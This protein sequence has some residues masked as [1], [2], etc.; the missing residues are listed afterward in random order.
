MM[1]DTDLPVDDPHFLLASLEGLRLQKRRIED[2]IRLV[3]RRIAT[4]QSHATAPL[5]KSGDVSPK[6]E[7]SVEARLR[8]SQAQ[9]KRWAEFRRTRNGA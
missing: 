6:R 3:E 8:I 4:L 7:L 9:K 2:Q 5:S 1:P